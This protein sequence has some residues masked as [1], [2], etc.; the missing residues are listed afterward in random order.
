M[1]WVIGLREGTPGY[2]SS[3]TEGWDIHNDRKYTLGYQP[4]TLVT[5]LVACHNA[6]RCLISIFWGP[7]AEGREVYFEGS[8]AEIW[9]FHNYQKQTLKLLDK[10]TTNIQVTCHTFL[11]KASI[12]PST[13]RKNGSHFWPT[14]RKTYLVS[15]L[16]YL[17]MSDLHCGMRGLWGF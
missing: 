14:T 7:Q 17:G 6:K 15:M 10:N 1:F 12:E 5:F 16:Q 2:S 13:T 11:S 3:K 9:E 8:K 4:K